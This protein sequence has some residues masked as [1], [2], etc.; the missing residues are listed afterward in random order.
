M[1]RIELDAEAVEK[2]FEEQTKEFQRH[3]ALPGFR[4]GK[5]PRDM[6]T[7]RFAAEIQD[8]V[9]K[10][11]IPDAYRQAIK[12]QKLDVLGYPDIEEVQFARGEPLQFVARVE[13]GPQFELPSYKGLPAKREIASVTDEDIERAINLLR[14]RQ[15]SYNTVARPVQEGDYVVVNYTGTSEGKPLTD[16]APTARG[17]T[18]QQNFWIEVSKTSFIPGFAEQLIGAS[19]GDKRTVEVDFP[20]DFVSEALVGKHGVYQVE[21]VE[22]KEQILPELNDEFAKSYGAESVDRLREGVRADLQNEMNSKQNRSI[23]N[24]VTHALVSQVQCDLPESLI[25]YE[26]RNMVYS[27][28][29]EN[30][31]RGVP[32]E[33]IDQ[34]KDQIYAAASQ[35]AKERV[36][37]GFV[38]NKVAE[39]EGIRVQDIEVNERIVR[40][41]SSYQMTPDKFVKELEK[42][43]GVGEIYE[44]LQQEKVI[45]LLVQYAK[46][47]DVPAAPPQA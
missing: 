13:T 9:K 11:L 27:I 26:T 12:D 44:Q 5:A 24:Q 42:R 34:Q 29:N 15:V 36:K 4:R 17:L 32:K 28:V 19:A 37:A 25:H 40:L 18:E 41:A 30:Q 38:L 10:K 43:N 8:E 35:A 7:T 6:I 45:N 33:V 22:V 16:I 20:Q 47:E 2:A 31:Q 46:I 39:K 21:V 1:L 14:E 23:R 3:A